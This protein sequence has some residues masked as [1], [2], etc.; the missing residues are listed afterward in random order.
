MSDFGVILIV[1]TLL[2]LAVLSWFEF[3]Q[4]LSMVLLG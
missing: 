4:W 1:S 3:I 2:A